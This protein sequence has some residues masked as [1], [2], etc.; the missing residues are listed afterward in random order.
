MQLA[1]LDYALG[2]GGVIL[3]NGFP[4][5]ATPPLFD[6]P[7]HTFAEA[8]KNATYWGDDMRFMICYGET[9]PIVPFPVNLTQ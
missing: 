1:K 3:Y 9:D 5:S 8:K 6:M 4:P 2:V 7:G